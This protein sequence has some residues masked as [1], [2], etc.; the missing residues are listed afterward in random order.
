MTAICIEVE[1]RY[2]YHM[3]QGTLKTIHSCVLI[4][5]HVK[6]K[7]K[8]GETNIGSCASPSQEIMIQKIFFQRRGERAQ[9][10]H[11][12][13]IF[14]VSPPSCSGAPPFRPWP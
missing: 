11:V 6:K 7:K 1:Y 5:E 13:M 3:K 14:S 9:E 8:D 12:V 2:K 10:V 4:D